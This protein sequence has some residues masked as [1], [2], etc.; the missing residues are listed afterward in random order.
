MVNG[1]NGKLKTPSK[2]NGPVWEWNQL[3]DEPEYL[4][5]ISWSSSLVKFSR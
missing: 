1:Y 2:V 5:S 3:A 4:A